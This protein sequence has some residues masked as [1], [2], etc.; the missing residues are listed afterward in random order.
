VVPSGRGFSVLS[1]SWSPSLGKHVVIGSRGMLFEATEAEL[2]TPQVSA[3][4]F[5]T[6]VPSAAPRLNAV[7][8]L[9]DAGGLVVGDGAYLARRGIDQKWRADQVLLRSEL[10]GAVSLTDGGTWFVGDD[11]VVIAPPLGGDTPTFVAGARSMPSKANQFSGAWFDGTTFVTVGVNEA[12]RG[13]V[14]VGIPPLPVQELQ[15]TELRAVGGP[16]SD[17]LVAVGTNGVSAVRQA[18][19]SW[20]G[21]QHDAGAGTVTDLNAI[22]ST[23]GG[24]LV[25]AHL[26]EADGGYSG[27]LYSVGPSGLGLVKSTLVGLNALSVA[28]GVLF[29]AG[30]YGRVL[31]LPLDGGSSELLSAACAQC[32]LPSLSGVFARSPTDVWVAGGDG[33]V[34]HFN[35]TAWEPIE[36]GTRRRLNGV[37]VTADANGHHWLWLYG[38]YGTIL[39]K[40]LD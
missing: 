19:G 11:G 28:G 33:V 31:R 5:E 4:A 30:D 24:V 1:G 34:A 6:V 23:E 13:Q 21:R 26:T 18:N 17:S 25:A 37:T 12:S 29:A 2:A 20:A 36:T 22:L 16:S 8:L 3:S 35:G 27:A 9:P 39:R 40:Q 10:R 7:A 32:R 14:F 15:G 38:E